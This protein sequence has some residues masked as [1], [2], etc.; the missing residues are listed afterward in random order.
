MMASGAIFNLL[1]AAAF[2]S[3]GE[4]VCRSTPGATTNTRSG[5]ASYSETKDAASAS[6]F[7]IKPVAA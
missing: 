5:H 4:K 1:R 6:V 7:A 3:P 2:P